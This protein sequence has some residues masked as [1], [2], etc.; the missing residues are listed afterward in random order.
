TLFQQLRLWWRPK[1]CIAAADSEEQVVQLRC[2]VQEGSELLGLFP[3]GKSTESD[4]ASFRE[5][6]SWIYPDHFH[7]AAPDEHAAEVG[8]L[9][10]VAAAAVAR[11]V[12]AG[13]C[14]K[15]K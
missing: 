11:S 6:A 10:F 1:Q 13:L 5:C 4:D 9:Q 3:V 12:P 7:F 14:E 8:R 15:H 2:V